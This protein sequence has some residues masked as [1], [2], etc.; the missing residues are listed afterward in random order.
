[1]KKNIEERAGEIL[2]RS[3]TQTLRTEGAAL[4]RVI[5]S[6]AAAEAVRHLLGEG[7]DLR[8]PKRSDEL[9]TRFHAH[10]GYVARHSKGDVTKDE[11]YSEALNTAVEHGLY[12]YTLVTQRV[13][14][15]S[16]IFDVD[17]KVPVSTTKA[18]NREL[19]EAYEIVQ[20][21]AARYGV[22]L[23]EKTRNIGEAA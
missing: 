21:I 2:A 23:P 7:I 5:I 19:L 18:S 8:E 22:R 15:N 9:S 14:I 20:D 16:A 10:C 13:N 11:V 1:M 17:V 3:L 12:P 4:D 6:R